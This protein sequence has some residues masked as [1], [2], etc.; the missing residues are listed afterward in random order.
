MSYKNLI[1][2]SLSTAFKLVKDL[3]ED[4]TL[5]K[6]TSNAFD[7]NASAATTTDAVPITV[8][9][10]P[11]ES[12]KRSDDRKVITHSLLFRASEITAI[13]KGDKIT[14]ATATYTINNVIRSDRFMFYVDASKEG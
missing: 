7:F 1:N 6:V 5:V 8:K 13:N 3:A 4:G 14:L 9:V 10:I 2:K 11:L 12:T